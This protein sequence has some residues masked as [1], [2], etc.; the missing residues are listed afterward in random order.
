[1][2]S[3]L[4]RRR[5]LKSAAVAASAAVPYTLTA[6]QPQPNGELL[7]LGVLLGLGEKLLGV[8]EVQHVGIHEVNIFAVLPREH[9]VI[10]VDSPRK[11][12]QAFVADLGAIERADAEAQEIVGLEQ[13]GQRYPAVEGS[14]RGVIMDGAIVVVKLHK[15]RVFNAVELRGRV[16]KDRPLGKAGECGTAAAAPN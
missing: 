16:G 12:S 13:F 6:A 11:Q 4:T 8:P 9:G 14:V 5:F 10:A 3:R 1:M 15:A 2:T 7:R